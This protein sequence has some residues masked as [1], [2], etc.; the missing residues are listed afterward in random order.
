MF[1]RYLS[2]QLGPPA[3]SDTVMGEWF[4]GGGGG[5]D[6]DNLERENSNKVLIH[7]S[8]NLETPALFRPLNYLIL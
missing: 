8:L 3:F 5:K 6:G 7:D 2:A 1:K 4:A